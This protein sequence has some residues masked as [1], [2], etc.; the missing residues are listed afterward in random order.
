MRLS[1]PPALPLRPGPE[2]SLGFAVRAAGELPNLDMLSLTR[3]NA[4]HGWDGYATALGVGGGFPRGHPLDPGAQPEGSWQR[5]ALE[6][7]SFLWQMASGLPTGA[8]GAFLEF[9]IDAVSVRGAATGRGAVFQGQYAAA[10]MGGIIEARGRLLGMP[11]P[12]QPR[13]RAGLW[14]RLLHA[15][16]VPPA[17]P[18]AIATA[19]S[20]SSVRFRRPPS[21][22]S[23]T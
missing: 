17:S 15:Y 23:A 4:L 22:P 13:R 19:V 21:D 14:T 9:S 1:S 20:A 6:A 5:R 8:H 10:K 11:G 7:G 12:A 2:S 3:Q 18:E 16:A